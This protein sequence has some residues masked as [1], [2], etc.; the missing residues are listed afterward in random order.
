MASAGAAWVKVLVE[1]AICESAG[2][3]AW[4]LLRERA[5]GARGSCCC[6]DQRGAM[7]AREGSRRL[8]D[9]EG[10]RRADHRDRGPV[11]RARPRISSW[12]VRGPVFRAAP[13]FARACKL[14]GWAVAA[15][16]ASARGCAQLVVAAPSARTERGLRWRGEEATR[17]APGAGEKLP[18]RE[19]AGRAGRRSG[20]GRA[21]AD[22]R[23]PHRLDWPAGLSTR[24]RAFG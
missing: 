7:C 14:V 17:G 10:G 21:S 3:P 8:G 22:R 23:K 1:P 19:A 13:Y 11:C 16:Y 9:H 6:V 15:L 2:H 12:R 20:I 4:L 24:G 18:A 5:C